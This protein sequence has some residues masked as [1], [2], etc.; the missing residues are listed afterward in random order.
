MIENYLSEDGV[1]ANVQ[2][3][4][5]NLLGIAIFTWYHFKNTVLQCGSYDCDNTV[6]QCGSCDCDNCEGQVLILQIH[7]NILCLACINEVHH[8]NKLL[9]TRRGN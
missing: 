4:K 7:N 3:K 6:L 5:R 2:P 8:S 1:L 9:Q